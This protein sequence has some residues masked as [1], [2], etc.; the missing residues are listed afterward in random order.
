MSYAKKGVPVCGEYFMRRR[1]FSVGQFHKRFSF[2][3]LYLLGAIRYL[4]KKVSEPAV[5]AT[6]SG[7]AIRAAFGH[8]MALMQAARSGREAKH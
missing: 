5:V 2:V 4:Q 1:K 8:L 6:N 7:Q 3:R